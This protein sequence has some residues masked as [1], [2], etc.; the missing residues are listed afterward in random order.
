MKNLII[1]LFPLLIFSQ[2]NIMLEGLFDPRLMILGDGKS[3][4]AG[5]ADFKIGV[6][7][8]GKQFEWY[9]FAMKA[10]YEYA[11]L[12]P[13]YIS[14]LISAGWTFN[15]FLPENLNTGIFLTTGFIHR[16]GTSF[17]TYGATG[18]ISYKLTDRLKLTIQY[19]AIKRGDLKYMWQEN[20]VGISNYLGI[21]YKLR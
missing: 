8:Q 7:L 18:E 3:Y 19:Q 21:K 11:D 12:K 14:Y 20:K 5:T 17:F 9:Y 10:Q 4:G 15:Q 6:E 16:F 13:R 2:E 1:L